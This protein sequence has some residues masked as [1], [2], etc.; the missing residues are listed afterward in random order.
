MSSEFDPSKLIFLDEKEDKKKDTIV[1][2]AFQ[3]SKVEEGETFLTPD[4]QKDNT[5]D[6]FTAAIAG[7]GSG[8][9]KIP[10]GVVSLGAELLDYGV[11]TKYA[12]EVEQF[13]DKINP[14]EEVAQQKASGKILEAIVSLG[15]PAGAGAKI[16]TNLA[17]KALKAKRAGRYASLNTKNA[18]KG[19]EKT[20]Q[21]NQLSGKQKFSAIVLGG[22]AGETM[23]ADVEDIGTFGDVFEG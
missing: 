18:K 5:V 10:E 15:V 4:A 3:P 16:A 23:V 6:S 1:L 2:P 20:I 14:F 9:I 11:G 7:I 17:T 21:K 13:F 19:L 8:I 22:A 12:V